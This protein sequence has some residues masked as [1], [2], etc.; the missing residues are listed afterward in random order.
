MAREFRSHCA[1]GIPPRRPAPVTLLLIQHKIAT[2]SK[3]ETVTFFVNPAHF[4]LDWV[5]ECGSHSPPHPTGQEDGMGE[6]EDG[7]TTL[8]G[9][10]CGEPAPV[11]KMT[12]VKRGVK[13]GDQ[14]RFRR[15]HNRRG[16]TD[17]TRWV[18]EDRGHDTPCWV[19]TGSLNKKGYGRA[20][21]A[22]EHTGAH[23]AIY[24]A[25][26]GMLARMAQLDHLCGVRCCVNPAHLEVVCNAENS[27]R[28]RGAK[29]SS[30]DAL[31]IRGSGLSNTALAAY[32]GVAQQTISD[33][34][35]NK[36]WRHLNGE[37]A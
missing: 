17:L 22:R 1:Y 25:A 31:A 6:R 33:I 12:R 8:C 4:S 7:G 2:C 19:W 23:R 24:E 15:G 11:A 26:N 18:L 32:Y 36:K 27:R 29:L 30:A 21:V 10:G 5:R 37:A 3:R 14:L 16:S 9:C 20:Q 13:A 34:R 28:G 35:R